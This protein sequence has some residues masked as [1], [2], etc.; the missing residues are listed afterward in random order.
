MQVI[1]FF[2]AEELVRN[3]SINLPKYLFELPE[4]SIND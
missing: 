3:V 4:K 1:S 2:F